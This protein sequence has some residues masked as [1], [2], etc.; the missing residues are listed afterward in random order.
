VLIA[1]DGSPAARAALRA[2]A[3]LF[4]PRQAVVV[5]VREAGR[6]VDLTNVPSHALDTGLAPLDL[7]AGA[8]LDQRLYA[9]ARRLA[10]QGARG[11]P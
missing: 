4:A 7:R 6:G 11:G 9:A 8:E 1:F 10:E 2:A 3:E 5:V